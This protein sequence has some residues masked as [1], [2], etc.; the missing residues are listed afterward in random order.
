MFVMYFVTERNFTSR[1][2]TLLVYTGPFVRW[3]HRQN[4]IKTGITGKKCEGIKTTTNL[5][6]ST[7]GLELE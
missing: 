3:M 4:D 6:I 7:R 1:N 2:R 5:T